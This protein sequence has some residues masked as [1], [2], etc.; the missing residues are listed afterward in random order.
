[1]YVAFYIFLMVRM[2]YNY[3][4]VNIEI[5][6]Y[7]SQSE[8]K[9]YLVRDSFLMLQFML[10]F[11]TML[12]TRI[13]TVFSIR[14]KVRVSEPCGPAG[15]S[16]TPALCSLVVPSLSPLLS[17]TYSF[18]QST[19]KYMES[20]SVRHGD[21]DTQRT[22]PCPKGQNGPLQ[23]YHKQTTTMSYWGEPT[24]GSQE[25]NPAWRLASSTQAGVF[26]WKQV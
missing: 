9:G 24:S 12:Q 17:F 13:I 2:R 23:K 19:K 11:V 22:P 8:E 14:V 4:W 26:C 10:W 6:H 20:L 3:F 21:T 15:P 18:T 1:M 7:G 5:I 25:S 16:L